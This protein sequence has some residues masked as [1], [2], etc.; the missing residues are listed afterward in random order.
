MV[1][2]G[3]HV[4]VDTGK[5]WLILAFSL[6]ERE[7]KNQCVSGAKGFWPMPKNLAPRALGGTAGHWE[8]QI[9]RELVLGSESCRPPCSHTI[10]MGVMVLLTWGTSDPPPPAEKSKW[11]FLMG[12]LFSYLHLGKYF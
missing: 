7:R 6:R 3:T 10:R 9:L 5:N 2:G 4:R 12:P 1:A 11:L 8:R